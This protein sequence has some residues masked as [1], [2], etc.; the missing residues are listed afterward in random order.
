VKRSYGQ[1]CPLAKALDVIGG[2]WTLL[3][4]RE[5]IGGPRR[6]KDLLDGLPGIG[7]NLLSDRLREL[8]E[9]GVIEKRT[10]PPPAGSTVYELT[11]RGRTLVPIA[12][13]LAQWGFPLMG[14]LTAEE[15]FRVHWFMTGAKS[16]FRPEAAEGVRLVCE[17]RASESDVAHFRIEDG[18]L[19][20]FHGPA[21]EPDLALSGEPREL[22]RLFI[23]AV[24]PEKATSNGVTLDG[25]LKT[26]RRLLG[27]FRAPAPA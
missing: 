14:E 6:F 12:V 25:D 27:I 19:D 11:E 3:L 24:P 5:L 17:M 4:V 15:E 1:Y 8:Q 16:A 18:A 10:L 20:I 23:G 21:Y 13:R 7:T 2:R 26:L 22:I 9:T